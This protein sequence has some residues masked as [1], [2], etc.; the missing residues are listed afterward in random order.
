MSHSPA[1]P[2]GLSDNSNKNSNAQ[3]NT[4][5]SQLS[6]IL[7]AILADY[8]TLSR[9]LAVARARYER[10]EQIVA[11]LKPHTSM[12]ATG[13]APSPTSALPDPAVK[14]IMDLRSHLEAEKVAR[15]AVEY[16]LRTISKAWLDFDRHL[17][18][19]EDHLSDVRSNFSQLLRDPSS[20]PSFKPLPAYQPHHSH[21]S[22][23]RAPVAAAQTSPSIS[24]HSGPPSP[25]ARVHHQTDRKVSGPW[26]H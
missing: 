8:E 14:M 9:D 22:A 12:T 11:L 23:S 7:L 3:S 24:Q 10:A 15:E 18:A 13:D 1:P 26:R 6:Q 21:Q 5:P 4:S 17:Q 2:P 25:P 19:S 20:Y 16:R